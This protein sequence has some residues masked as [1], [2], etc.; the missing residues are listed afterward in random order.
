MLNDKLLLKSSFDDQSAPV[1]QKWM[2]KV[3]I[4]IT[5]R[6]IPVSCY[7]GLTTC[8]EKK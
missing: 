1:L 7:D 3:W 8:S 2:N 4:T 5:G 6:F